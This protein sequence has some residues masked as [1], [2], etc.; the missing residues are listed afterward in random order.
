MPRLDGND[1]ADYVVVLK[2]EPGVVAF[3]NSYNRHL[4][5]NHGMC[6]DYRKMFL[7]FEDEWAKDCKVD[8]REV[9]ARERSRQGAGE[10][11]GGRR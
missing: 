7:Q 4:M 3:L 2:Q 6:N 10:V 1:S 11:A 9:I 5:I 8:V